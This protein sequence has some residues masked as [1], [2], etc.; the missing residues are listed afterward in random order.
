MDSRYLGILCRCLALEHFATSMSKPTHDTVSALAETLSTYPHLRSLDLSP[1]IWSGEFAHEM[2]GTCLTGLASYKGPRKQR[3]YTH[4][5][6]SL[7]LGY[8]DTLTVVYLDWSGLVWM[9][10]GRLQTFLCACPHLQI[11]S[12]MVALNRDNARLQEPK[13]GAP[14]IEEVAISDRL[15]ASSWACEETLRVLKV[16]FKSR[17]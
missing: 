12:A 2:I 8:A 1:S 15:C 3:D 6:R 5:V 4:V 17:L 13:M 10:A 11:F 9:T 16:V 14:R 7:Q